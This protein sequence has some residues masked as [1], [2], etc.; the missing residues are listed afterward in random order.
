VIARSPASRPQQGQPI[1]VG[2][3]LISVNGT[4]Y[5]PGLHSRDS[6]SGQILPDTAGR[7]VLRVR[8]I[9]SGC[10]EQVVWT[11]CQKLAES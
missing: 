2:D 10:E 8:R 6:V 4:E 11:N 9:S 7:L 1:N 5:V 3:E